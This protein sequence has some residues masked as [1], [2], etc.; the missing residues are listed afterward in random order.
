[1]KKGDP[2]PS[3]SVSALDDRARAGRQLPD[4][5]RRS[6]YLAAFLYFSRR[7]F[8]SSMRRSYWLPLARRTARS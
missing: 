7:S 4:Q 6:V 3:M 2:S 1:M 8:S 5:N